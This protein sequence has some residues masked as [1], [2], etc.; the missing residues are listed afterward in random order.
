MVEI[1]YKRVGEIRPWN[2]RIT[3]HPV[4]PTCSHNRLPKVIQT[5][6]ACNV[7]SPSVKS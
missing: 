6:I 4:L 7:F 2:I 1:E 3:Y 5:V